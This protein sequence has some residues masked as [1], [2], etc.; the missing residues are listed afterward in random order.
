MEGSPYRKFSISW[1]GAQFQGP[2][3]GFLRA[4]TWSVPLSGTQG[5]GSCLE[6]GGNDTGV[7]FPN[8]RIGQWTQCKIF[9]WTTWTREVTWT[10]EWLGLKETCCTLME[11]DATWLVH[12]WACDQM[13]QLGLSLKGHFTR[14]D[15]LEVDERNNNRSMRISADDRYQE[16]PQQM[17]I[18][19]DRYLKPKAKPNYQ[20]ALTS[21]RQA[22]RSLSSVTVA[23]RCNGEAQRKQAGRS[24]LTAGRCGKQARPASVGQLPELDGLAHSAGSSRD[25]L[26][27]AGL[28]VQVLG[29]LVGS[30]LW[31]GHVGDP[32]VPMGW[33]ALGIKP[34]A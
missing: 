5:S 8:R 13:E 29:S 16:M 1:K 14:A 12:E 3:S 26:N 18:N 15:H 2:N 9:V 17:K 28:S 27:S 25:P 20:N 34:G 11:G 33:L 31:P 7:F 23:V 22:Q 4:G 6:A 32:C 24:V 30:G 21:W 10:R 19:I